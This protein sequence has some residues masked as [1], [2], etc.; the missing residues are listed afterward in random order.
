MCQSRLC[1]A[2]VS[3]GCKHSNGVIENTN[4]QIAYDVKVALSTAGLPACFWPFAVVYVCILHNITKVYDMEGYSMCPW[5]IKFGEQFKGK[6]IQFGCGVFYLPAPT[7]G[8]NTKAAPNM[9]YGISLD[10]GPPLAVIG[11]VSML[12]LHWKH[13]LEKGLELT[14]QARPIEYTHTTQNKSVSES[15][16]YVSS[17]AQV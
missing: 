8:M 1:V 15:V 2:T 17:K 6:E 5:E 4:L 3:T 12:A 14:N 11:Q 9:S 10:T 7:K 16:E 13:S